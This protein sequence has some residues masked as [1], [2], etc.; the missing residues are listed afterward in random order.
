[1]IKQRLQHQ[2]G[3]CSGNRSMRAAHV[4][5]RNQLA[6]AVGKALKGL[7][8]PVHALILF[9]ADPTIEHDLHARIICNPFD[10]HRFS[11]SVR[12]YYVGLARSLDSYLPPGHAPPS[13]RHEPHRHS[14]FQCSRKRTRPR[15]VQ[16]RPRTSQDRQTGHARPS[17]RSGPAHSATPSSSGDLTQSCDSPRSGGH[18]QFCNS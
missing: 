14:L 2:Y 18:R 16:H 6:N 12:E 10:I 9:A 15:C 3:S 7:E 1:V 8:R 11:R 5:A 17:N 13:L 4:S